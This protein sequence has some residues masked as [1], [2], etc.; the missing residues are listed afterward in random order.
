[1]LTLCA[2]EFIAYRGRR[3]LT[4]IDAATGQWRWELRDLANDTRVQATNDLI[5]LTSTRWPGGLLLRTRDGR[6]MPFAENVREK[7]QAAK[8]SLGN[9]LLVFSRDTAGSLTIERWNP[10][11]RQSA[12]RE[13]FPNSSQFGWLDNHTLATLSQEGKLATFDLNTRESLMLATLKPTDLS[14]LNRQ[15]Y[16]VSDN[17]RVFLIVSGQQSNFYGDDLITIPVNGTI[18][19]FDRRAGGELWREKVDNQALVMNHF[20]A[21]PVLLFSTR[22]FEQRGKIHVQVHRLLLIDKKT[23]RK[24]LDNELISQY[25]GFRLNLN[26]AERYLELLTYNDRV[27]LIG[28]EPDPEK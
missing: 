8:T 27:R 21:S 9:D 20:G 13:S 28:R 3:T 19:A 15:R 7:F 22:K 10:Q 5:F 25:S 26:L 6:S 17:D 16:L 2:P 11:T 1:L 23:G 18:F 24:Q 14:G 4:M 12:W